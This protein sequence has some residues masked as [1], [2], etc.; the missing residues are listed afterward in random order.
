MVTGTKISRQRGSYVK[1][2]SRTAVKRRDHDER[3]INSPRMDFEF[4]P[5]FGFYGVAPVE[6]RPFTA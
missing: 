4:I 3:G 2:S 1:K 6:L 5:S